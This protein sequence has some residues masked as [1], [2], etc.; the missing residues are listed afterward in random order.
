METKCDYERHPETGVLL[1]L[2]DAEGALDALKYSLY[3]RDHGVD[4]DRQLS[5][6]VHANGGL[7]A[8]W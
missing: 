3:M 6:Q 2:T 7:L 5:D 8:R 4:F 1:S